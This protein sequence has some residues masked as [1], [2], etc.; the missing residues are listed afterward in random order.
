MKKP[1][2][3]TTK[4][5]LLLLG[6]IVAIIISFNSSVVGMNEL[7]EYQILSSFPEQPKN[8]VGHAYEFIIRE[9]ISHLK[10]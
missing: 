10:A 7:P 2:L 9:I 8:L 3:S 6:V 4:L 5:L 1:E